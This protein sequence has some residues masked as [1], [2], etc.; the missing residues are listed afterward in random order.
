MHPDRVRVATGQVGKSPQILVWDS[1]TLETKSI[2]KGGHTDGVGIL[3]F[4]KA[5]DVRKNFKIKII[6]PKDL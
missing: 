2:L 1:I 4:N 3:T 6:Q 5:G